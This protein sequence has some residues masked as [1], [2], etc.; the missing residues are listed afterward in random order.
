MPV[1]FRWNGYRF[2]FFANEGDPREP[3]H[4]H[5]AKAGADAKFWLYPEVEL[6]YNRGFDARTIKRLREVVEDRCGEIEELWNDFF[7]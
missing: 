1:V 4:V 5:I 6:A 7:S 3:V 2:H